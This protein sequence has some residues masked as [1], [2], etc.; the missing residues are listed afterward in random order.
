MH[1]R[2]FFH[3]D[4]EIYAPMWCGANDGVRRGDRAD[5]GDEEARPTEGV[6][7]AGSGVPG[8]EDEWSGHP[9]ANP[10]ALPGGPALSSEGIA[11]IGGSGDL[12]DL[13]VLDATDPD[14]GLTNVG[15]KPAEDWAADTGPTRTGEAA[16]HG[17][18]RDLTDRDRD[19]SGRPIDFEQPKKK[20]RKK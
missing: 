6:S 2:L 9:T 19:P 8:G 16:P 20:S 11:E 1:T 17:V 5:T 13:T 7:P 10:S 14:L 12:E 18:S 4:D 15:D 3:A